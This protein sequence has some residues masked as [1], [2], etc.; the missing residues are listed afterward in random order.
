MKNEAPLNVGL[1]ATCLVDLIHLSMGFA[2][3]RLLEP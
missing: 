3:A 1:F 2:T